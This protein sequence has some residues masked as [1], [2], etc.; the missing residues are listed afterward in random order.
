VV[1]QLAQKRLNATDPVGAPT[2]WA[3]NAQVSRLTPAGAPVEAGDTL[4]QGSGTA[5]PRPSSATTFTPQ[6]RML[7]RRR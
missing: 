4:P 3:T 2:R 5:P 1:P 7:G 6:P